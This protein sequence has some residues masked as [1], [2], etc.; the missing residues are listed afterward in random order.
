MNI[1]SS[2]SSSRYYALLMPILVFFA[3]SI[4]MLNFQ[5]GNHIPS[6][7]LLHEV[8]AIKHKVPSLHHN[9]SGSR[10]ASTA[11]AG[12]TTGI[13]SQPRCI[14]YNPT[15]RTIR[16]SCIF[17]RISDIDNIVH[18]NAVLSEESS[19][20]IWLL[21]SNLVI[22]KGATLYIN[23]TDTKWLKIVSNGI[24]SSPENHV[25]VFGGLKVDSVKITSWN[26]SINNY[27][28]ITN[29]NTS[30]RPYIKI[31]GNATGT[32]DIT[33]SEIAYLGSKYNPKRGAGTSGL[34][35]FNGG[36]G[37]VL[38]GNNIHNNWYGVYIR[39]VGHMIIENNNSHNN[40]NYGF[41]P[42]TG[43]HDIVIRHNEVHDNGG[44]GIICSLNC[45]NITFENNKVY[46]NADTG[47][48]FSKNTSNSVARNNIVY[49]EKHAGIF[50]SSGSHD[51]KIYNNTVLNSEN[52]IYLKNYSSNNI[53]HDNTII[54]P[55]A[56]GLYLNSNASGNTFYSNTI[57]N[58]G[59]YAIYVQGSDPVNNTFKDNK[60]II[61]S[62]SSSL[63]SSASSLSN[64]V[65]IDD[66]NTNT[67]LINNTIISR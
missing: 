1:L 55:A 50:S 27:S 63:P 13:Y 3:A 49:D 28:T 53:V 18:D 38:R 14:T 2:P 59:H 45:Y 21:N 39:G 52:G 26:S 20:G 22:S 40:Y 5:S 10:L 44:Q 36:D 16:V 7:I 64:V 47:I 62:S 57:E 4:V 41:D 58:A 34:E 46:H 37:S 24:S 25:D 29:N 42:H 31:E 12:S 32:A 65:K 33:N 54:H 67:Q 66:N 19:D 9:T 15:I 51:N 35:Y 8:N 61:N 23:S 43:S 30:T 60:L 17:A 11:A 48:M 6:S 56:Y